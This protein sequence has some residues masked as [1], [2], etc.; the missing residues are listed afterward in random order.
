MTESGYIALSTTIQ[1]VISFLN[2]LKEIS[3]ILGLPSTQPVFHC[4]VW[5]DNENCIKV[6]KSPKFT[7]QTKHI[8]IKYHHFRSF[9]QD[10]TIS[11]HSI[12]TAEQLADIFTKPLVEKSFCYL[13]RELMGW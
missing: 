12:D 6:A 4:K 7:P 2:L 10:E 3:D 5:E 13:R 1:E 11:I 8:V 9:V